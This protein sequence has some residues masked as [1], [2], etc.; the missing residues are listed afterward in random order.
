M[1]ELVDCF[2]DAI[3]AREFEQAQRCLS[4]DEFLYTSPIDIFDNAADFIADISRVG[5]ILKRI[6]RRKL[7]V[8]GDQAC[9]IF[10]L[11]ATMDALANTRIAQWMKARNGKFSSIEVFFDAHAYSSMFDTLN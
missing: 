2:L 8:D 5:P 11:I 7:F 9:A 4:D 6:E 10:N 1:R 3:E